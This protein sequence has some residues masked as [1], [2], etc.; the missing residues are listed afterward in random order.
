MLKEFKALEQILVC[1]ITR[2]A[3]FVADPLNCHE[4]LSGIGLPLA[5]RLDTVMRSE[6]SEFLIGILLSL[7]DT[8][9]VENGLCCGT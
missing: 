1:Q 4:I 6:P 3:A 5:K 2:V 8:K 7:V 9:I